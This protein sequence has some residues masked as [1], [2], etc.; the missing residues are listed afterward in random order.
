VNSNRL[1]KNFIV[2]RERKLSQK[3][4][5]QTRKKE[6]KGMEEYH[7]RMAVNAPPTAKNDKLCREA[8]ET[9]N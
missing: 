2:Q 6:G 3:Q 7:K 5:S 9:W 8:T 1:L 4:D